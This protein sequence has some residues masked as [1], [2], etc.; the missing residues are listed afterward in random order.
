LLKTCPLCGRL[1]ADRQRMEAEISRVTGDWQRKEAE[2]SR[3]AADRHLMEAWMEADLSRV[4][5]DGERME[6]EISS[7][8]AHE[9]S[10]EAEISTLVA[11]REWMEAEIS[12]LTSDGQLATKAA[13]EEAVKME[14]ALALERRRVGWAKEASKHAA[15]KTK[16]E[17]EGE[18]ARRTADGQREQKAAAVSQATIARM[19][20]EFLEER[21]KGGRSDERIAVLEAQVP[22][23]R[24]ERATMKARVCVRESMRKR[25]R[26]RERE[27]ESEGESER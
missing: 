21:R 11:D 6:A 19:G 20:D 26:E 17:L 8:T 18:M 22:C 27:I 14:E 9:Q 15:A 4:A 13:Q 7:L 1:A 16:A 3:V 2:L 25:K 23:L 24:R 12:K 10:M 5:A